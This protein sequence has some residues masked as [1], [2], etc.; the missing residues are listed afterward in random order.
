[1]AAARVELTIL[2][3]TLTVRTEA[4]AE[5]M[6]SLAAYLDERAR[7]LQASGVRDAM[8]AVSM[9]AIE[10]VDELFRARDDKTRNERDLQTRL[11]ALLTLLDDVAPPAS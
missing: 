10:I 8:T 9:A 11:G 4:S 7:A 5:Y 3:Q 6:Q 1:M 2:G